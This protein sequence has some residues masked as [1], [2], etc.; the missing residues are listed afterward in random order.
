M[1]VCVCRAAFPEAAIRVDFSSSTP[2]VSA[3]VASAAAG[4]G[5]GG[6]AA[7]REEA[8][9]RGRERAARSAKEKRDAKKQKEHAK[10]A[11]IGSGGVDGEKLGEG[12]TKSLGG[13]VKEGKGKG[14]VGGAK[15][16]GAPAT[17][18]GGGSAG[19][20]PRGKK[21]KIAKIKGKYAE[22]DDE[23]REL[24]MKVTLRLTC[25]S[26]CVTRCACHVIHIQS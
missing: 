23:D 25:A 17:A 8:A 20:A 13:A 21:G 2:K 26:V 12:D 9:A 4:G 1:C 24:A 22:Q 14:A 10:A 6:D 5:G 19:P 11:G 7:A 18:K 3:A 15:G 16:G